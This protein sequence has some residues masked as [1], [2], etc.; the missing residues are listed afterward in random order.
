MTYQKITP[1]L[2][3]VDIDGTVEFYTKILDFK[4]DSYDPDPAWATLSRDT[5]SLMFHEPNAHIPFEK[6][7]FTGSLYIYIDDVETVWT[8]IKESVE[9]CYPLAEFDYGMKEFGFYDNNGYLLKFGQ[10]LS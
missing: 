1:M 7:E 3:T 4:C 8:E 2:T 6:A 5:V 10:A 9:I